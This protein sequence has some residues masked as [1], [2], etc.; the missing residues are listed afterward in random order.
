VGCES[1]YEADEIRKAT[2][3]RAIGIDAD[4]KV[5]AESPHVEFHRA[6]IGATDCVGM[7]FYTNV[8]S[9]LSSPYFRPGESGQ[10]AKHY[11]QWR[12]DTFCREYEISPDALIVDAEGAG[13]DVLEGCGALLDSLKVAYVEVNHTLR[14]GTR[15]AEM[16]DAL[17]AAHGMTRHEGLPSYCAG[18]QSN[19]TWVRK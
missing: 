1:A 11:P 7:T 2:G 12:L 18:D 4:P 14:P 19:W 5:E 8:A 13:L 3:C 10:Q 17:M 6:L 15:P 9:G 16:C